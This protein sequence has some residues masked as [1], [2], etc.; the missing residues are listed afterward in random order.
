MYLTLNNSKYNRLT[1]K[2]Y[3]NQEAGAHNGSVFNL[4]SASNNCSRANLKSSF[5]ITSSNQ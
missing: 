2:L 3:C 5:T 4:W 1:V